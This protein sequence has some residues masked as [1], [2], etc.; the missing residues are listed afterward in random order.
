[1][2]I[3]GQSPV[4][5]MSRVWSVPNI[6]TFSIPF[7]KKLIKKYR[8][9]KVLDLFIFPFDED[10]LIK[11]EKIKTESIDV[12][13]YDP[14]YSSNMAKTLYDNKGKNIF[15]NYYHKNLRLEASRVLKPGGI[16]IKFGWDSTRLNNNLEIIE[17]ILIS[18]GG[19][20]HDTIC[21]IQRKIIGSILNYD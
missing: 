4:L 16:V 6:Q 20:H 5:K 8:T 18:H 19:Q 14:P 21:T 12:L 2:K 13:L 17:V 9:G 10:V 11:L 3:R 7:I 1:M 15:G